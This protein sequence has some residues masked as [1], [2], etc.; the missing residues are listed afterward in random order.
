MTH[1]APTSARRPLIRSA[2]LAPRSAASSTTSRRRSNHA[3]AT[4]EREPV[5]IGASR[6]PYIRATTDASR[7]STQGP[8]L[9]DIAAQ[10]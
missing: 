2:R 5:C 8:R 9:P 1:R 3:Q 4:L 10:T 6:P 7:R